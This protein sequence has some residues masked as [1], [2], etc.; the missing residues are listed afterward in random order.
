[1]REAILALL[2]SFQ[3]FHAEPRPET[4]EARQDR[5]RIAAEA[6]WDASEV[7]PRGLS[8]NA[9]SGALVALG[10]HE[11]R[12][13]RYVG[14]DRCLD[15]PVEARCD[16]H[17]KTGIPQAKGYFQAH[18]SVCPQLW[19]LEPASV[20]WIRYSARCASGRMSGAYLRCRARAVSPLAGA[21]AGYRGADCTWAPAR[22]RA[23]D[24]TRF[25]AVLG[26]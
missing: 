12:F 5:L 20:E 22:R 11:S 24:A 1:M 26:G 21:F 15:G 25:A 14:D 19:E 18:R 8:R 23:V 3:P 16:P 2:L 10:W 13:A 7:R 9:W 6:I 4:P 17:R